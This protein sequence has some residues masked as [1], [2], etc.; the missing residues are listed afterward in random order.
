MSDGS[1]VK[2]ENWPYGFK[3]NFPN[4]III[5]RGRRRKSN[6]HW[7]LL[8]GLGIGIF[9]CVLALVTINH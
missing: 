1:G 2:Y 5:D 9:L 3:R 6:F 7:G 4:D 8:L